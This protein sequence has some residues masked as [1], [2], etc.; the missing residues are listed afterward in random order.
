MLPPK[1]SVKRSNLNV[2]KISITEEDGFVK[3]KIYS[4]S[5][6]SGTGKSYQAM[7]LCKQY[8]IE[9]IIDDG[10]F[11]YENKVAAGT[12]AKK[13]KTV[14]GAVKTAL[15][16]YPE[17]REK[18]RDKIKEI[19]PES[20]VI[21]GTSDRMIDIIIER[22]ELHVPDERIYI[23]DV[24][25][26]SERNTAKKQRKQQGEHVIPAPTFQ[27][28]RDFAGYFMNPLKLF[29]SLSMTE[30]SS[31]QERTVVRPTFSYAGQYVISERV[32]GDI[33][34]CT[35]EE[36]SKYL[37]ISEYYDN[38]K[39]SNLEIEIEITARYCDEMMEVIKDF[40]EKVKNMVENMTAFQIKRFDVEIKDIKFYVEHVDD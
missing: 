37:F 32:L 1:I 29:K 15:F 22:L 20:I 18:V 26:E 34:K 30:N 13:A 31:N 28:K 27:L 7:N 12:S 21:I 14:I 4:F 19:D 11:I 40:Q 23:A 10:L 8:N 16:V 33:I 39:T 38:T 9:G 36:Y 2:P 6:E 35:A 17:W 3:M 25:T 5:G 24:T